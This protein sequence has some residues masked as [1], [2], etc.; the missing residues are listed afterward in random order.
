MTKP[1][2]YQ[3]KYID[4]QKETYTVQYKNE[5]KDEQTFA[6]VLRNLFKD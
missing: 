6:Q 2:S 3:I 1:K 5:P 4:V